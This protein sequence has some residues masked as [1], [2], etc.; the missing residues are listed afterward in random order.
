MNGL[1]ITAYILTSLASLVF[2]VLVV[3]GYVKVSQLQNALS[4]NPLFGGASSS[5]APYSPYE[6]SPTICEIDPTNPTCGG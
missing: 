6:G 1:R 2:L 5:S 4:T 3:Y